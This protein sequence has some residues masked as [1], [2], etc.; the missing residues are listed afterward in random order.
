MAKIAVEKSTGIVWEAWGDG[1]QLEFGR[2]GLEV[3]LH[4]ELKT[5]YGYMNASE[6]SIWEAV[7]SV[8]EDFTA[9]K[10]VHNDTSWSISAECKKDIRPNAVGE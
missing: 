8:P 10:Y 3:R 1:Y 5:T 7:T 9:T 2:R 4:D 6:Y